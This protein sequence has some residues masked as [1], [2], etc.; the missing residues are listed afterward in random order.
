MASIGTAFAHVKDCFTTYVPD[1]LILPACQD[2]N[3]QW[4]ERQLG[5]VVTTYLFLQQVAHGNT[6]C[7]HLRHLSGMP[8]NPSAYCQARYPAKELARLYGLRWGLEVNPRHLKQTMQMEILGCTTV[9]GVLKEL[10]VFVGV[11]HLVRH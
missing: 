7:T 4:R 1:T 11:Y 2:V 10:A 8:V 9:E 6:A 3:H 5:P